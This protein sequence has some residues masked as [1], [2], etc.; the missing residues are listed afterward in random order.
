MWHFLWI[1]IKV[2]FYLFVVGIPYYLL[3]LTAILGH[4]LFLPDMRRVDEHYGLY[5][6]WDS[7]VGY[8]VYYLLFFLLIICPIGIAIIF[9]IS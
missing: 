7:V 2:L 9:L 6:S 8:L 5:Q 3:I 1:V 4:G